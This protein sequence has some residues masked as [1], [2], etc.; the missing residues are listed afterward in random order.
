M[1]PR[2]A[3]HD[4]PLA[5][6]SED[7]GDDSNSPNTTGNGDMARSEMGTPKKKLRRKKKKK[8][9]KGTGQLAAQAAP[10]LNLQPVVG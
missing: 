5:G 3:V 10:V 2:R 4:D 6:E 9:S 1:I 8:R 7:E